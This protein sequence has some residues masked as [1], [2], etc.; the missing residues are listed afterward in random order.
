MQDLSPAVHDN[1][2]IRDLIGQQIYNDFRNYRMAQD[3][4]KMEQS[5]INRDPRFAMALERR[6]LGKA[7]KSNSGLR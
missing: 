3:D 6:K 1:A 2:E 7:Q 4:F 5:A